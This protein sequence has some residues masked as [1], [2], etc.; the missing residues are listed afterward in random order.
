MNFRIDDDAEDNEL[1]HFDDEEEEA[2]GG[3]EEVVEEESEEIKRNWERWKCAVPLEVLLDPHRS[4]VHTV[5]HY[6]ESIQTPDAT[7]T[8]LIP[9]IVPS[10][11]N[12]ITAEAGG[13][14]APRSVVGGASHPDR[15]DRRRR[16]PAL[17]IA[18][19]EKE[20]PHGSASDH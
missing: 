4:L 10:K 12:P 11:R 16:C 19:P 14:E 5:L 2:G 15:I 20:N 13:S 7:T 1:P 17:N 8:V 6:V 9:E 3:A 18:K